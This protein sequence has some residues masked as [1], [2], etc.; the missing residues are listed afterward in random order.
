MIDRIE[1]RNIAG[2]YAAM[3]SVNRDVTAAGGRDSERELFDKPG[4][5]FPTVSKANAGQPCPGCQH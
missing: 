1:A 3:L 2:L 4:G 5:F